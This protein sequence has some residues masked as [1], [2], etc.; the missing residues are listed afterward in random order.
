MAAAAV[1][2]IELGAIGRLKDLGKCRLFDRKTDVV[3]I[4]GGA[5]FESG[6]AVGRD[7]K[8]FCQRRYG[9]IV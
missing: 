1:A 7:F 3:K 9:A 5:D 8:Q 4:V 2:G 6:H